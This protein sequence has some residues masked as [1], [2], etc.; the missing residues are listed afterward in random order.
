[1]YSFSSPLFTYYTTREIQGTVNSD[2]GATIRDALKSAVN[3]GVIEEKLM[4]Y[5][6]SNFKKKPAQVLYDEALK[7][8]TL[9]YK[10]ILNNSL[11]DM[12]QCLTEGFPFVFGI[13]LYN[14]FLTRTVQTT[15]FVTKP[16]NK[17]RLLGGHCMLCHGWFHKN[18]QNYFIVQNSWGTRW[19]DKGFCYIPFEYMTDTTKTLDLWTIRLQE[20]DGESV[21]QKVNTTFISA[22]KQEKKMSLD[23]IDELENYLSIR[24]GS[25]L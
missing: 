16:T 8:Q 17:E 14:S 6:P 24:S 9:V 11:Q 3:Y 12:I 19:G 25:D 13:L 21:Q 2:S 7:H 18:G 15:G 4:P 5:I 22:L 1:V 23:T 20:N 10:R